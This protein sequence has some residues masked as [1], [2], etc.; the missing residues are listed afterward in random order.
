[1]ISSVPTVTP[2]SLTT[3]TRSPSGVTDTSVGGT[4]PIISSPSTPTSASSAT[5]GSVQSSLSSS[6]GGVRIGL[7]SSEGSFWVSV[8]Q[9]KPCSRGSC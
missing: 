4:G 6:A 2:T 7:V 9:P 1:V 5:G 3:G 8:T